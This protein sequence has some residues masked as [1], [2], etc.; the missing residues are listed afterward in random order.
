LAETVERASR[1]FD[2]H[3]T[4][5]RLQVRGVVKVAELVENER[6]RETY[7]TEMVEIFVSTVDGRKLFESFHTIAVPV[8]RFEEF[9]RLRKQLRESWMSALERLG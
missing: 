5:S 3:K 2:S 1:R 9:E 4:R 7:W 6:L 8:G